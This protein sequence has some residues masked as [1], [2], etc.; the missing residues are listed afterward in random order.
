[1]SDPKENQAGP[2]SYYATE[3]IQDLTT[4]LISHHN[5]QLGTDISASKLISAALVAMGR[6]VVTAKG[7]IVSPKLMEAYR[8]AKATTM[9]LS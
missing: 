6:R 9:S 7:I 5:Q 1:V 3:A 4:E 2:A 8:K